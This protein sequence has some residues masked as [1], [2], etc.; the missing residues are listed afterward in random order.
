MYQLVT[1]K[2]LGENDF[3]NMDLAL[4]KW[5]QIIPDSKHSSIKGLKEQLRRA[6]NGEIF[7][8]QFYLDIY[9]HLLCLK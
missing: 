5:K 7:F 8:I 4:A 3:N 9:D 2:K 1:S 6:P